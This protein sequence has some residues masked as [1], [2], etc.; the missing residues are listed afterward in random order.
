MTAPDLLTEVLE[1]PRSAFVPF[2]GMQC[3]ARPDW[4]QLTTP[5]MKGGGLNSVSL[6]I[7]RS[8]KADQVI[9]DTIRGYDEMGLRF[10]WE[11]GPDSRPL[12]LGKR[13]EAR[14]LKPVSVAGMASTQCSARNPTDVEVELVV[15][16]TLQ[17]FN[18][19]MS[20]GWGIKS[21]ALCD[22]NAHVLRESPKR[23]PFFIARIGGKG[24]GVASYFAFPNSAFLVG[25][26]VLQEFRK[27]GVYRALVAARQEHAFKAGRAVTTCHAIADSSAPTLAKIGFE[28]VCPFT[29]YVR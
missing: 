18:A 1:K 8:D 27:R 29:F 15:P 17:E 14:G 20:E 6:A 2:P 9:G 28:T 26:V 12:D 24:V 5:G 22:Y 25:G 16:S 21:N 4:H 11:V 19:L 13:L 3:I 7:I 10:R 23:N